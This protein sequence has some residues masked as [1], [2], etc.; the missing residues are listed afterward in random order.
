MKKHVIVAFAYAVAAMACGVFYREFTK[1]NDFTGVTSL[2]KVHAPFPFGYG[3][4]FARRTVRRKTFF[5]P[6][7]I[8]Q[9]VYDRL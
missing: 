7:K 4:V 8:V 5:Q 2:G 1:F 9:T 3:D 6:T